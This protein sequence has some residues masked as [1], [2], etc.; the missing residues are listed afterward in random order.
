MTIRT[1]I[2]GVTGVLFSTAALATAP[3]HYDTRFNITAEV[4]DSAFI[5]DPQGTPVTEIDLRLIPAGS[6]Y[7]RSTALSADTLGVKPLRLWS[8]NSGDNRVKITLDDGNSAN[9][10]PFVLNS[11][12]GSRL[13]QMNYKVSTIEG[14]ERKEFLRS[15]ADNSY[16]LT[17]Q[18]NHAEKEI[19]FVVESRQAHNTY[20]PGSYGGVVYANVAVIP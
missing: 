15:G 12:S 3:S 17:K 19:V 6:H 16:V 5:T 14:A 18:Q 1:L 10:A 8:N 7:A 11:S 9:G 4:P 13:E 2:A 20:Q